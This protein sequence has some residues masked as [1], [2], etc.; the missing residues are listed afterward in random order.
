MDLTQQ[1]MLLYTP[2]VAGRYYS[3]EIMD[4]YTNAFH[5]VGSRATSGAQGTYAL[6][7]PDTPDSAFRS[8]LPPGTTVIRCPQN[9]VWMVGRFEV[10][11]GDQADLD[12][13]IALVRTNVL[14]PLDKFVSRSS[15]Y[16]NPIITKPGTTVPSLNTTG[17]QFFTVLNEWMTKNPSPS[18]DD[19]VLQEFAKI[20]IG[21]GLSTNFNA[22]PIEQQE[23]MLAGAEEASAILTIG[24]LIAGDVYNGWRYNLGDDFGNWGTSYLL[25]GMT[26]RGGLGANINQE[27]IYPL[28]VFD[29]RIASLLPDRKY[30][31]TFPAGQLPS[32]NNP[33]FWSITMYDR[34][35]AQLVDNPID[36][37]SIGS[38]NSLTMAL[39]GS[40]TIYIQRDDPGGTK[41]NN[42]LPTAESGSNPFYLIF[43]AYNP[44]PIMY[45]PYTDPGYKVPAIRRVP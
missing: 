28:L 11:P 2:A 33:G 29:D 37:Y 16:V 35:S 39:D 24:S 27:A 45:T 30:E 12:T 43:R 32:V 20:G 25:R 9:F 14:L 44:N 31:I 40:I 21:R 42:W 19:P 18:A 34:T 6:V 3:W 17:L 8:S 41:T 1:P 23:A 15:S 13:V 38:Q 4:A 10:K 36:R 7:G 22:L 26:A 5:Y